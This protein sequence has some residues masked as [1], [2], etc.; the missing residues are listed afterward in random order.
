MRQLYSKLQQKHIAFND[1]LKDKLDALPSEARFNLVLLGM[2]FYLL[3][4]IIVLYG[5]LTGNETP[6]P[7]TG[8]IEPAEIAAPKSSFLQQPSDT[9]I[10]QIFQK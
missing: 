4:T 10:Y 8:R 7:E 5:A 1:R 2:A 3:I 9:T 6:I